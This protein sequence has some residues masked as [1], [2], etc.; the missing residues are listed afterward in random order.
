MLEIV[1]RSASERSAKPGPKN[2][3]NF[4]TTPFFLKRSVM[5]KTRSVAV[6]PEGNLPISL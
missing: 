1:E 3:T 4:S 5:V 2:S 6:T